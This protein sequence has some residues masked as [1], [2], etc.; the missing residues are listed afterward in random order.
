MKQRWRLIAATMRAVK[1]FTRQLPIANSLID[2]DNRL[3]VSTR[4]PRRGVLTGGVPKNYRGAVRLGV[5]VGR[6]LLIKRGPRFEA[7]GPRF[8]GRAAL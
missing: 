4:R 8:R 6:A 2:Y 5:K 1:T 7:C 3:A